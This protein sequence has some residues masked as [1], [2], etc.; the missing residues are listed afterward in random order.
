MLNSRSQVAPNRVDLSQLEPSVDAHGGEAVRGGAHDSTLVED[1]AAPASSPSPGSAASE[2][3]KAGGFPA[4]VVS[5]QPALE[6]L[7]R[8]R[9]CLTP[10]V[11]ASQAED[12]ATIERL[13]HLDGFWRCTSC[14]CELTD[15][16]VSVPCCPPAA[17][18]TR[19]LHAFD[20]GLHE[21]V[22]AASLG[23]GGGG[24]DSDDSDDSD[25][26]SSDGGGGD[27]GQGAR[28][29]H[30]APPAWPLH[31]PRG[32][33]LLSWESALEQAVQNLLRLLLE[34][35]TIPSAAD[36]AAAAAAS[37]AS[38]RRMPHLLA[39]VTSVVGRAHWTSQALLEAQLDHLTEIATDK[40]PRPR[41]AR[42][43]QH[44]SSSDCARACHSADGG[45][46]GSDSKG[47]GPATSGDD[48]GVDEAYEYQAAANCGGSDVM[49]SSDIMVSGDNEVDAAQRTRAEARLCAAVLDEAGLGPISSAEALLRALWRR[50]AVLWEDRK[51]RREGEVWESLVEVFEALEAW[52]VL[53]KVLSSSSSAMAAHAMITETRARSEMEYGTDSSDAQKLRVLEATVLR[54]VIGCAVQD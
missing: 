35:A 30:V 25:A 21:C 54:L 8:L 45:G 27:D 14:S 15:A 38:L 44:A 48:H 29:R 33:G 17:G 11:K 2:A 9:M 23:G 32:A 12:S 26:D 28:P 42:R 47:G 13:I 19:W 36:P 39:A 5:P 43:A 50:M 52:G 7:T 41:T 1:C 51:A 31:L 3:S 46:A 53:H 37:A 4:Q 16:E 34:Q 18:D 49:S 40:A 22:A 20:D 24:G 6:R 10:Q